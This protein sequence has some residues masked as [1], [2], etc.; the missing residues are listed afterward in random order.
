MSGS[1]ARLIGGDPPAACPTC[2]APAGWGRRPGCWPIF[3]V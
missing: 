2:A 1:M 3:Q